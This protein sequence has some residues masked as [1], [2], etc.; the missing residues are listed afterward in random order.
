MS[1]L[2]QLCFFGLASLTIAAPGSAAAP[3]VDLG[4]VKYIGSYNATSG[5]NYFRGI[6]FA[7]PPIGELRW[8]KPRPI[9]DKNGFNGQCF[10]ATEPGYACHQGLPSY[11]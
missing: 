3:I 7:Q 9:E 11:L 2:L 5:I 4:Y 6:P 10:S 1:F 8:R